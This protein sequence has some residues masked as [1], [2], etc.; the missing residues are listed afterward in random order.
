MRRQLLTLIALTALLVAP[1]YAFT[2]DGPTNFQQG[3]GIVRFGT[4]VTSYQYSIVNNIMQFNHYN[5]GDALQHGVLGFDAGTGVNMT[6][7]NVAE[8]TVRYNVSCAGVG[9]TYVMYNAQ[10]H[11]PT[12]TNTDNI[13]YDA[14]T[15]IATVT[16]T[17]NVVVTLNYGG[18]S[19]TASQGLEPFIALFPI[20]VMALAFEIRKAEIIDNKMFIYVIVIAVVALAI[21]L[22]RNAGF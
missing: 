13:A 10:N 8:Y 15:K 19:D 6:V 2:I 22:L 18:L 20:V 9:I 4:D 3:G 14:A 5:D 16:T 1:T 7:L 21:L 11:A 17:G 12:G